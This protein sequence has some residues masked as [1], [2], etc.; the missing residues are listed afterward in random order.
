MERL[1]VDFDITEEDTTSIPFGWDFQYASAIFLFLHYIEE[2]KKIIVE[3]KNQ[4]VEIIFDNY[5]LLA[6][7]KASQTGSVSGR[8][9]K[10]KKA[11]VSL[12]KANKQT[13]D[14]LM[15]ICNIEPPI[16]SEKVFKNTVL[17]LGKSE[18]D[19][20]IFKAKIDDVIADIDKKITGCSKPAELK[21]LNALRHRLV[22][23]DCNNIL[24]CCIS[25]FV[26]NKDFLKRYEVISDS[27]KNMLVDKLDLKMYEMGNYINN[28]LEDWH[29]MISLDAGVNNERDFK[30]ISRDRMVWQI[31]YRII[32]RNIDPKDLYEGEIPSGLIDK[33]CNGSEKLIKKPIKFKTVNRI[34]NG[35]R[36]YIKIDA[37]RTHFDFAKEKWMEYKDLSS[38]Y[39]NDPLLNEYVIKSTIV[40]I[41]LN[42]KNVSKLILG[43]VLC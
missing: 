25:P 10:I 12:A 1:D 40:K 37:T 9:S 8:Y 20:N 14:K 7:A 36:D 27:L 5:V 21:K 2:A 33:L 23:F 16:L 18:S 19:L 22:N 38:E 32:E 13:N 30:E 6:Q 42:N 29:F 4:D 24:I 28:V 3:G 35:F 31:L 17:E 26:D 11:V 43:G 39:E 34:V 15:Y 41:L